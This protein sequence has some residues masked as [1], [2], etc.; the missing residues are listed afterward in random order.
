MADLEQVDASLREL[1]RRLGAVAKD[2]HA[3]ESFNEVVEAEE[4][5]VAEGDS[6]LANIAAVLSLNGVVGVKAVKAALRGWFSDDAQ[7]LGQ[8][9]KK[10]S[11]K[12][13]KTVLRG[14]IKRVKEGQ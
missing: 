8:M 9:T 13:A 14:L 4:E 1:V 3:D 5:D 2:S 12:N 6:P 7:E 11:H 10:L